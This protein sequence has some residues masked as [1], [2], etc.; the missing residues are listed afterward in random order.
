M[1]K[2]KVQSV[3]GILAVVTH[4]SCFGY[5]RTIVTER[6]ISLTSNPSPLLRRK[7]GVADGSQPANRRAA[8]LKPKLSLPYTA[9]HVDTFS[10]C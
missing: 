10:K 6:E 2:I 3:M 1:I 7:G 8:S 5:K 4:H 9:T